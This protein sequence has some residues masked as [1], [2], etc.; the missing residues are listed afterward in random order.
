MLRRL[1]FWQWVVIFIHNEEKN[2]LASLSPSTEPVNPWR[3][4]RSCSGGSQE[5]IINRPKK[6]NN[7]GY[8]W[9]SILWCIPNQIESV[10]THTRHRWQSDNLFWKNKNLILGQMR[11]CPSCLLPEPPESSVSSSVC[12]MTKKVWMSGA[13]FTSWEPFL[14]LQDQIREMLDYSGKELGIS[15]TFSYF[16]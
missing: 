4:D 7:K 1:P 2:K 11:L 16:V 6:Y 12:L 14:L 10:P 13:I 9:Q 5:F 3:G 8:F 15:I